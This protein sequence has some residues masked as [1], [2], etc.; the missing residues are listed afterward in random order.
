VGSTNR[1]KCQ[2]L[3][4]ARPGS[5]SINCDKSSLVS[6]HPGRSPGDPS[7]GQFLRG[8]SVSLRPYPVRPRRKSA[9]PPALEYSDALKLEGP[10][11]TIVFPDA[12]G[13]RCAGAHKE[14][15]C[16]GR[17]LVAGVEAEL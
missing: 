5:V 4:K 2:E 3:N 13:H 12:V 6:G 16:G 10:S 17:F 14:N 9:V 8:V 1:E 11:G 7:T 15:T